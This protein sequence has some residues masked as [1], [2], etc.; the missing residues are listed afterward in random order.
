LPGVPFKNSGSKP[1]FPGELGSFLPKIS[2]FPECGDPGSFGG[3]FRKKRPGPK[4]CGKILETKG[5]N[6]RTPDDCGRIKSALYF[7][8]TQKTC[9]RGCPCHQSKRF[10]KRLFGLFKC[11]TQRNLDAVK[12]GK[13]NDEIANVLEKAALEIVAKYTN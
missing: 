1:Q 2:G 3:V 9:S 10:R 7:A 4:N 12:S 5:P 8:G 6:P 13:W 11:Q